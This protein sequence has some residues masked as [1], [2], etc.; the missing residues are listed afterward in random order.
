MRLVGRYSFNGG[1]AAVQQKYSDLLDEAERAVAGVDAGACR[2]KE[3][4]EKTMRGRSLYSPVALNRAF[5]AQFEPFIWDL[6]TRGVSN[7]DIPA[8]V[9]GIDDEPQPQPDA[10]P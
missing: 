10:A 2:T 9:L 7:I 4:R 6:G 8:L 5:K 1:E 3:S